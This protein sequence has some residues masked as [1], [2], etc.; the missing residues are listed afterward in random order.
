MDTTP[1]TPFHA[2]VIRNVVVP[3]PPV[4]RAAKAVIDAEATAEGRRAINAYTYGKE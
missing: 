1:V 4:N 3:P 2:T